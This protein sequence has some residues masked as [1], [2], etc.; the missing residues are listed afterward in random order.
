MLLGG[1]EGHTQLA[2]VILGEEPPFGC[3]QFR[4]TNVSQ[5]K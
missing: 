2:N 5:L 1:K 4:E 3:L